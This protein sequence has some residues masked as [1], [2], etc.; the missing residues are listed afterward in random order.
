VKQ[1]DPQGWPFD[2]RLRPYQL[3]RVQLVP[4]GLPGPSAGGFEGLL[5]RAER[6]SM[7]VLEDFAAG[8]PQIYAV[9]FLMGQFHDTRC[10]LSA[11]IHFLF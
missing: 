3:L 4:N 8:S 2:L 9:S 1:R 7:Q 11:H 6:V 10:D 5:R